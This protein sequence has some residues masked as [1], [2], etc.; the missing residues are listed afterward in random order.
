MNVAIKKV[1]QT[2]SGE[3]FVLV[4]PSTRQILTVH[5]AS[6]KALRQYFA[7]LGADSETVDACFERARERYA[8]NSE[9][10]PVVDQAADTDGDDLL[11]GLGLDDDL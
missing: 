7:G 2:E 3:R 6:E 8:R 10:Q 5:D 1:S 4:E 11:A 9:A